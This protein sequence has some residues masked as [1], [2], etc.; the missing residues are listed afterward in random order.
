MRDLLTAGPVT[1]DTLPPALR[2]NWVAS[3]GE[4][5]IEV[6]PRGDANDNAVLHRFVDA[7]RGVAPEA[8]GAPVFVVEAAATI[9]RAFLEAGVLSLISIAIILFVRCA[10]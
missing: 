7:V 10:A 6:A 4:V 1:I 3:D 2:S 5:R 9:V 8:S